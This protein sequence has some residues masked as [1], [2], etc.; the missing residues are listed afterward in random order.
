ML[1]DP[2]YSV[3]YLKKVR[4]IMS[5]I[6][7]THNIKEYVIGVTKPFIGQRLSKVT[8]KI[9]KTTGIKPDSVCVSVSAVQDN[10]IAD[11]IEQFIPHIKALVERTQDLIIRNLH[12][13]KAS[14]VSDNDINMNAVLEYLNEESSG[15][16]V[17]KKDASEWFDS[18]LSDPLAVALATKLGVSTEPSKEDSD[19]IERLVSEFKNNISAL[20]AGNVKYDPPVCDVLSKALALAP[21]EDVMRIKFEKRLDN[22]R[23]KVHSSISGA[24]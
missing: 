15:G 11:K 7:N 5:A 2:M 20:T 9:D 23:N 10:D 13:S 22:M 4:I 21:E 18:V 14:V 8:Y 6:S 3:P 19:K 16:R 17:T 12:E 1:H 24:L